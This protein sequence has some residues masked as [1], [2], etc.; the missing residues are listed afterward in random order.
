M[1]IRPIPL[2]VPLMIKDTAWGGGV[3]CSLARYLNRVAFQPLCKDNWPFLTSDGSRGGATF[4]NMPFVGYDLRICQYN[5]K[6]FH[7]V[8]SFVDAK[9]SHSFYQIFVEK[10]IHI[11]VISI[12][13]TSSELQKILV[14]TPRRKA[15]V[16]RGQDGLW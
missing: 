12:F 16:G 11:A 10:P 7:F 4:I 9:M 1:F 3:S 6:V 2:S 15:L 14:R 13:M 8:L 5:L